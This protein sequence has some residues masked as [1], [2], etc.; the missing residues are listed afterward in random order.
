MMNLLITDETGNMFFT[1]GIISEIVGILV[2]RKMLIRN[3]REHMIAAALFFTLCF[4]T[5]AA[6]I[7]SGFHLFGD[8]AEASSPLDDR[9]DELTAAGGTAQVVSRSTR[10][11]YTAS[12][13]VLNVLTYLISLVPG[14]DEWLGRMRRS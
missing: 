12:G 4:A 1:Y 14:G 3:S 8:S 7:W 9:L 11:R 13:G 10:R 5:L 6:L 2:I